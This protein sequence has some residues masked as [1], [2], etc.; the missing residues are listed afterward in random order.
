[1]VIFSLSFF[2]RYLLISSL[3]SSLTHWGLFVFCFWGKFLR[4]QVIEFFVCFVISVSAVNFSFMLLWS[5]KLLQKSLY[6]KIYWAFFCAPVCGQ[7]QRMFHVR[8]NVY[9][10]FV[11]LICIFT[12]FY[13]TILYWFCHTLTWIHHGCTCVP[14]LFIYINIMSWKYQLSLNVLVYHLGFLLP[15]WF[16]V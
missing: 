10:L 15:Y 3:L 11:F 9:C 1:M 5:E 14:K 13:F 12:L 7:P 2:L 16:S 8:L 4:L 6:S